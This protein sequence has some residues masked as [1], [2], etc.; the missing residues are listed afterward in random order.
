MRVVD[1]RV[2]RLIDDFEAELLDDGIGEDILGDPFDLVSGVF[3]RETVEFE[4]EEFSLA[5]F[6]DLG[7]AERREGALDG[8]SLGLS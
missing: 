4:D 8:L 1:R 6:L 7:E 3:A 5:H 2:S